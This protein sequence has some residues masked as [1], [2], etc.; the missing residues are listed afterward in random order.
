M[1]IRMPYAS[2]DI[3]ERL[4]ELYWERYRI[5][6]FIAETASVGSVARRRQWLDESVAAV[7]RLR[8][9]GVPL[10]GYTWWPLF[11]LVTWAYRQGTH[12]PGFYLKQ[13]GL[14]DLDPELN[15]VETELAEEYRRLVAVGCEC[16]GQLAGVQEERMAHVS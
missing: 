16:V 1:R 3:V 11:A 12:P 15:R 8:E 5:P 9:N 13:M 2:A 14:W 10:I 7:R 6:V 4:G